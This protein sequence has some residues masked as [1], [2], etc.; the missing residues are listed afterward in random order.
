M[1]MKKSKFDEF[2]NFYDKE[3]QGKYAYY[4]R[5][6]WDACQC[7]DIAYAMHHKQGVW[8]SKDYA[9]WIRDFNKFIKEKVKEER[10]QVSVCEKIND[11]IQA[12]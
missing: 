5:Q 3:T 9:A 11:W 7:A 10:L 2:V 8:E 6:L 1:A 4:Y 12:L